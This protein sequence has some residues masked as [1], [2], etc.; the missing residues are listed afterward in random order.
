MNSDPSISTTQHGTTIDVLFIQGLQH[1]KSEVYVS[2]F[3]YHKPIQLSQTDIWLLSGI[4]EFFLAWTRFNFLILNFYH[5]RKHI[6]NLNFVY[7]AK[8]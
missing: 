1:S 5:L 4:L 2:Y 7:E 6:F 3:S 8:S